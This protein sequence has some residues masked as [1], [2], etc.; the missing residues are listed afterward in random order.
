MAEASSGH[1]VRGNFETLFVGTQKLR[2]SNEAQG[3]LGDTV[4]MAGDR[5]VRS[6]RVGMPSRF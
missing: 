3:V 4:T 6:P 5:A 1:G 2:G